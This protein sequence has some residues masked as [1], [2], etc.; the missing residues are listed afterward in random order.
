MK[1]SLYAE[2]VNTKQRRSLD[3]MLHVGGVGY[4]AMETS[5]PPSTAPQSTKINHCIV[6]VA[7]CH[8]F[9]CH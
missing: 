2:G 6:V 4:Q 8:G 5:G 9:L 7:V 3:R 1:E